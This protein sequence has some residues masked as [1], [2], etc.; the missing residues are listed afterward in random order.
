MKCLLKVPTHVREDAVSTPCS[1]TS[2]QTNWL[3]EPTTGW[4]AFTLVLTCCS[5]CYHCSLGDGL[6]KYVEFNDCNCCACSALVAW[7]GDASEDVLAL[8]SPAELLLQQGVWTGAC[9]LHQPR[10]CAERPV[11]HL[12]E[13]TEFWS[14]YSSHRGAG[15]AGRLRTSDDDRQ[16]LD[17]DPPFVW[18]YPIGC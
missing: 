11:Q 9:V 10:Q 13:H 16:Q 3:P 6:L 15:G 1:Q 14:V 2:S 5:G 17:G 18:L 7:S 4:S 8:R 12:A